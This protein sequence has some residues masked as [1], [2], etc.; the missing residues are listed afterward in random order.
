M[1]RKGKGRKGK[2]TQGRGREGKGGEGKG[3]GRE[4]KGR[5]GGEGKG[6][7]GRDG[8]GEHPPI[9]YCTP[10][11]QFSRNMF[12]IN[13]LSDFV[14]HSPADVTLCSSSSTF[15]PLSTSITP[16]SVLFQAHNSPFHETFPLLAPTG[17]PPWTLQRFSDLV[18]F[19]SSYF[20]FLGHAVN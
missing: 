17:L 16:S 18:F 3:K 15:C 1:G 11:F 13:F 2:G 19:I 12:G 9:F 8:K 4:G 14:S 6:R 10:Q 5:E 7:E 20:M